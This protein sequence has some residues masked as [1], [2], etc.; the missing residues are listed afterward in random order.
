MSS[1]G[2][3][4]QNGFFMT[5]IGSETMISI[6]ELQLVPSLLLRMAKHLP[7]FKQQ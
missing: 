7:L 1:C 2:A 6:K 4:A 5:S 3:S